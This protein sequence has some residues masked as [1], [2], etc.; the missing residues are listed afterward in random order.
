MALAAKSKNNK[1]KDLSQIKCFHCGKM[2]HY[3]TNC[4]EK[5][6]VKT[7]RDVAAS[8]IVEEF[9]TKFEQEFSLVS[10][11]SSIGSYIFEHVWVVDNGAT[12]HMTGVYDSFQI[13]TM[14]GLGHFIQTYIDNPHIAIQGV[15]TVR[16]QLDLREVLEV[17]G[18]LFVPSMRVN[19]LSVSSFED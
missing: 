14:L 17:H 15:G 9:A 8:A 5:N 16:F 19:K 6:I 7:E 12:R 3:A 2:G 11:D 13:I 1:K 18:V 10:V 4:L